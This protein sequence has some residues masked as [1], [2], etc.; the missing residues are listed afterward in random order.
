[1]KVPRPCHPVHE[2]ELS[3]R[4]VQSSG[5]EVHRR[6]RLAPGPI[7]RFVKVE[8]AA[9]AGRQDVLTAH[10]VLPTHLDTRTRA[11]NLLD[12]NATALP[13]FGVAGLELHLYDRLSPYLSPPDG[14]SPERKHRTNLG[15]HCV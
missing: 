15:L 3:F 2:R 10:Q 7:C 1:M 12:L 5:L 4:L 8:R 9:L 14:I 11:P 13:G 6:S